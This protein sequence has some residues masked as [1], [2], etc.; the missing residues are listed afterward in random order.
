MILLLV[1]VTASA[2]LAV[3]F[4]GSLANLAET[5]FR[6]VPL[7]LMGLALQLTVTF[8]PGD[9]DGKVAVALLIAAN[10]LVAAFVI[11][12]RDMPGMLAMLAG[13]VLN[14]AVIA[15]NGG[16][17]VSQTAAE[18]AGVHSLNDVGAEH[19]VLDAGTRVPWLSD[20]IPIPR[21]GEVLSVGDL[22]LAAGMGRLVYARARTPRSRLD[23]NTSRN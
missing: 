6:L 22:L 13:L 10:A 11:A 7:L 18:I 9:I 5:S 1:V 16:M 20:V 17:P 14:V 15:V 4:G 23:S 21:T 19:L 3:R 12:N 8:A 2:L